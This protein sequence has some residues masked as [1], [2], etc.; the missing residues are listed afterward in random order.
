MALLN[1]VPCP[2]PPHPA[3]PRLAPLL[4]ASPPLL[5]VGAGGA[6]VHAAAGSP[7]TAGPNKLY[8]L[9]GCSGPWITVTHGPQHMY[10][11]YSLLDRAV[12]Q[13]FLAESVGFASAGSEKSA[14]GQKRKRNGWTCNRAT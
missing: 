11:S 3:P 6:G 12:S 14:L 13:P 1:S 7:E 9:Y 2:A 10:S 4:L 8:E 5:R